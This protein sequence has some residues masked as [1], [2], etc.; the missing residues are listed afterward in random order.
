MNCEAG[1]TEQAAGG[2]AGSNSTTSGFVVI[3]TLRE[4]DVLSCEIK[5]W[6]QHEADTDI[7]RAKR[8][9]SNSVDVLVSDS[10]SPNLTGA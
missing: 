1:R 6:G 2:K 9:E 4:M 10:D 8:I 3:V 5:F 7:S